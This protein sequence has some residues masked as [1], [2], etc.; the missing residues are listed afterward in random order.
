MDRDGSIS[1]DEMF[2]F[3]AN[4]VS[5]GKSPACAVR[6]AVRGMEGGVAGFVRPCSPRR[7]ARHASL[8]RSIDPQLEGPLVRRSFGRACRRAGNYGEKEVLEKL[9]N[10]LEGT[11]W[12]DF[13]DG[14]TGRRM[15][16][17]SIREAVNEFA[18]ESADFNSPKAKAKWGRVEDWDV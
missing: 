6:A 8:A 13:V 17:R 2:D 4:V 5:T 18:T 10:I 16:D 12:T 9:D 7:A 11:R 1:L 15:T 3:W 14:R